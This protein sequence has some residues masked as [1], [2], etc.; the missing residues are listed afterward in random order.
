MLI[1]VSSW[2]GSLPQKVNTIPIHHFMFVSIA[3][4]FVDVK[5]LSE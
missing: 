5:L 2:A 3:H 1:A 4:L